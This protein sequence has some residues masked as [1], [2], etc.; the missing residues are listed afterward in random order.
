MKLLCQILS[1]ESAPSGP[2][3]LAAKMTAHPKSSAVR[4]S[5]DRLVQSVQCYNPRP[6][7]LHG[8]MGPF[9]MAYIALFYTWTTNYIDDP[10]FTEYY[11]IAIGALIFLQVL[12]YLFSLWNVH[13]LAFLAFRKVCF[14]SSN[15]LFF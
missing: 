13:C 15:S 14:S 1:P 3:P 2:T 8:Y 6:L 12:V 10:K 9:V 4:D 5:S 7:I 11:F